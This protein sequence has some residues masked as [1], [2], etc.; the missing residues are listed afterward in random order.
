LPVQRIQDGRQI[1]GG[2]DREGQRYQE[3]DVL[4]GGEDAEQDREMPITTT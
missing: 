4:L 1:G 2:G 3:R